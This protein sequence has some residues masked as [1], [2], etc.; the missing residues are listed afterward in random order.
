[1]SV[2]A[3]NS[4]HSRWGEISRDNVHVWLSVPYVF[5][6]LALSFIYACLFRVQSMWRKRGILV[7]TGKLLKRLEPS[8]T[9]WNH[10]CFH[11]SSCPSPKWPITIISLLVMLVR[12]RERE[13]ER[14]MLKEP[15]AK[16]LE[17]AEISQKIKPYLQSIEIKHPLWQKVNPLSAWEID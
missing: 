2:S 12:F 11:V 14:V 17:A 4:N 15:K 6:Q 10:F 13:R 1:M 16:E 9:S 7:N 3:P 5:M 8:T